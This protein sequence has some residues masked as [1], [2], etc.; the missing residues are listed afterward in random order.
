MKI[1]DFISKLYLAL[2]SKTKYKKGCWGSHKKDLWYFDCVCLI[3]AIL[4][5]WDANTKYK[6]GG[7]VYKS[8]NVPDIGTEKMIQKCYN[9]STDFSNLSLGELLYM[10]GHVGI[11]VGDRYVIEATKAWTANVLKSTVSSDGT[12]SYKNKK[13]LKW[14]KH[15][16]LPYVNY[17]NQNKYG[18]I[19]P[20]LPK[21]G[22]FQK[23]DKGQQVKYL[24]QFLNW[25]TDSNIKVDGIVGAET[26]NL[27]K[28][29]QKLA[30]IKVDGLFG[31]DSLNAAYN[32]E[33]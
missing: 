4:W 26:I 12:R 8:N 16:F 5:G 32:F 20:T 24:Q 23:N 2:N 13:K 19:F 31:K 6:H 15:G 28:K 27:V 33:K 14:Q 1:N 3:K 9:V 29:F 21:R 11:Y 22:Y 10:K 25:A 7:A 17:D 30:N 18:G